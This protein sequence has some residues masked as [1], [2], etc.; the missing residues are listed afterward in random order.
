MTEFSIHSLTLCLA[1]AILGISPAGAVDKDTTS[2]DVFDIWYFGNGEVGQF[3]TV[4]G[5]KNPKTGLDTEQMTGYV[6]YSEGNKT[7]YWSNDESMKSVIV[8]AVNTWTNAITNRLDPNQSRKLRIGVFLD[9][10]SWSGST[11]SAAAGYS[12]H[13]SVQTNFEKDSAYNSYSIV[14]WTLVHHYETDY[15]RNPASAWVRNTNLLPSGENNIDVALFLN[16][17]EWMTSGGEWVQRERS[18]E[19]LLKVATHELGH[20]MGFDSSLYILSIDSATVGATELSGDMTRWDSLLTLDGQTVAG[21]QLKEGSTWIKEATSEYGS[22]EALHAAAWNPEMN[23]GNIQYDPERRLSV[24]L[25][26]DKTGVFVSSVV[27]M[28]N[29]LVH[30][31]NAEW[32]D[33]GYYSTDVMA[34]G[35]SNSAVLSENDLAALRMLGYTLVVPEPS[36]VLL[37]VMGSM[38]GLC[39][40]FRRR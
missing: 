36:S 15:Y 12:Q 24:E 29:M 8:Q 28:G 21:V 9:D 14:E 6:D 25:G 4:S 27:G 17:K 2:N 1:A 18:Q 38:A 34:A 33:D 32:H 22:L 31:E 40:R 10:D 39:V 26:Q 13:Y 35:G 3:G 19:D 20:A 16:P 11:M 37:L 23:P 5:N 7:N 30:L